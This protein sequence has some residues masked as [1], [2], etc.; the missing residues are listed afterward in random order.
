MASSR[1]FLKAVENRRSIYQLTNK[2][3]I[4]DARVEEIAKHNILHV[5]S[6]FNSQSTRI[7]LLLN[8]EHEK[9]WEITKEV[10]KPQMP[11]EQFP[12]TEKKLDGFK[13]GHG[14][15][16][17]Y[18][19]PNPVKK[20]QSQFALYAQHFPGWATQ[21]NAMAQYHLWTALEAEGCGANLQHYNPVVDSRVC[22]EWNVPQEW[23]LKAQ[24]VFGGVAEGAREAVEKNPK[25][26]QP[27]EE[28]LFIH[29]S[30]A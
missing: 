9:F 7:V 16:L 30:K 5:P 20:L 14:T 25:Q 13:A 28:R 19:D 2:I 29:G 24:L 18:E 1:D 15:I 10:L 21:S 4:S 3:P 6:S 8:E 12:Q 26:Q 11:E 27:L 17:F 23:E 22:T